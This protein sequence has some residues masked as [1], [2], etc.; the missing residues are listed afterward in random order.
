MASFK[1]NA[2]NAAGT[3]VSGTISG[4]TISQAA[5]KL[6]SQ[7]LA[8]TDLGESEGE[9]GDATA[10]GA[11]AMDARAMFSVVRSGDVVLLFKQLAS[12]AASGITLV[13]ALGVLEQQA[14]K[15]RLRY[16]LSQIRRDVEAGTPLSEAMARFP[17]TFPVVVTST[18]K[19]GELSGLMDEALNRIA[20]Q[21]E[22]SAAFRTQMFSSLMYPTVLVVAVITVSAFLVGYV[23]PKIV[24]FLKVQGGRL[25]WNTRFLVEMSEVLQTYYPQILGWVG[26]VAVL[27]VVTYKTV[28]G[29]Y[30][31]DL[32]KMRIPVIGPTFRLAAVVQFAKTVSTLLNSG[33]PM[34]ESLKAARQTINNA[35]M[36]RVIDNMINRVMAG[37][38]LSAPIARATGVFTPIIGS[39]VKM[40]EETGGM[41]GALELAAGI[42]QTMLQTRL[43]RMTSLIEPVLTVVM[44][45][46]VGFVAWALIAGMM[47]MY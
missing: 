30:L 14:G 1:Y 43:K 36:Q 31:I 5:D 39:M 13:S 35:A 26:G 37:D 9:S 15:R 45:G 2:V 40:G 21:L 22:D 11:A 27:L 3:K 47:S 6:R 4:E 34:L 24:P 10:G 44:G 18:I 19:A 46:I 32:Y 42:H 16:M 17:R 33:V 12:L 28:A 20:G 7:G 25:P 23:I 41:G 38:N 29:R 8:I